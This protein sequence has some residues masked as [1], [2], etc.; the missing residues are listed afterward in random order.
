MDPG[1]WDEAYEVARR[2]MLSERPGH[3][4]QP[5]ALVAEVFLK[6]RS[7]TAFFSAMEDKQQLAK[8]MRQVLVDHAR[9]RLALKRDAH[10]RAADEKVLLECVTERPMELPVLLDIHSAL[11]T[12]A[13]LHSRQHQVVELR[14]FVGATIA[15]TATA[16]DV[17]EDT[18]RNDWQRAVTWLRYM[19]SKWMR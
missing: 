5:T 3:T 6:C 12:L 1:S 4:L 13:R 9:K 10:R 16:I 8:L 15:E 14:V 18:V 17:C 2:V 19:L 7:E 11:D